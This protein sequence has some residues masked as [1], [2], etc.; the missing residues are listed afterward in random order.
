VSVSAPGT[1]ASVKLSGGPVNLG[2]QAPVDL[3]GPQPA[4]VLT[5]LQVPLSGGESIQLVLNFAT[6]GSLT[7]QVPVE[8]HAYEYA[9]Y[10]S[11]APSPTATT[12]PKPK[13]SASPAPTA[14]GSQAGAPG[15][16]ASPTPSPTR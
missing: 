14:S 7:I 9:T 8:P 6:A 13:H 2:P 5:N 12:T 15:V 10:S 4:I 3:E 16:S 11:P 1:A